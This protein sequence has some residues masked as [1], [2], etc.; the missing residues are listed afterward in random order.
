MYTDYWSVGKME[1]WRTREVE[2]WR[3]DRWRDGQVER[4]RGGEVE[5]WRGG[6]VEGWT[7]ER[8]SRG[9]M[10][11]G[12]MRGGEMRGGVLERWEVERRRGG[13]MRGGEVERWEI[14]VGVG[15]SIWR[16][17]AGMKHFLSGD[18]QQNK[19]W[20]MS[21]E[22][23]VI[24]Q[25]IM[26]LSYHLLYILFICSVFDCWY[27]KVL[28]ITYNVPWKK[29]SKISHHLMELCSISRVGSTQD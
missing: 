21:S 13:D 11:S 19:W 2:R 10:K 29:S 3:L 5:R 23:D 4:W 6:E 15:V 1:H 8:W 27:I 9:E 24:I 25:V 20:E 7:Y 18:V 22:N 26:S 17:R 14:V 16:E 28:S 12:E